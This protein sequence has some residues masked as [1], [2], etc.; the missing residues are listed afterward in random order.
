MQTQEL[1]FCHYLIQTRTIRTNE[2]LKG[3]AAEE[4]SGGS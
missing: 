3:I 1:S 4:I 2:H